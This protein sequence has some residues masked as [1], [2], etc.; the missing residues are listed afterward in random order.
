MNTKRL[1]AYFFFAV[2]LIL[3]FAFP[4][5]ALA[6]T[7]RTGSQVIVPESEVVNGTLLA[8]GQTIMID[9]D[10]KGDIICA[11]QNVD[12]NGA[13]DGDII[14]AGQNITITGAVS[15]SVRCV[16]QIVKIDGAVGRNVTVAAQTITADS[17]IAGEML[18]A[19]RKADIG[20]R[21]GGNIAGAGNE[22]FINGNIAGN[23]DFH[24]KNLI[25]RK[26][27]RI[28]GELNYTSDNELANQGGQ[29]SGSVNRT[30]PA[31]KDG[32]V[33]PKAR[34]TAWQNVAD[35]A[36]DIII[37]MAVALALVFLF[38][39]LTSKIAGAILEKPG[40]SFG[41][42]LIIMVAVP[43]AAIALAITIIGIPVAILAVLLFI[44][45]LFLSR[46]LAALAV[47][48]KITKDYWKSKQDSPVAQALVGVAVLWV[49]FAI[50]VVGGVFSFAAII[51]GLGGMRYL[52]AKNK[53]IANRL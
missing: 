1:F 32:A 19:G 50:P 52:F 11:G 13:V 23:A 31:V 48:R 14:C 22:I 33:F 38:K 16:G 17:T 27:S 43:I 15:G 5:D 28:G 26:D 41:W 18:F 4:K 42:G 29:V 40:R 39:N 45:A 47:G 2:F 46:I 20:G 8:S 7:A 53:D 24:D 30:V 12:I 9:G 37:N 49:L 10:I 34:K 35:K 21:I 51:W 3:N 44:A 36:M 6:F 25:L